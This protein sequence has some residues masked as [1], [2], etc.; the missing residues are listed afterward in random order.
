MRLRAS[1]TLLLALL[2]CSHLLCSALRCRTQ[3]HLRLQLRTPEGLPSRDQP[4]YRTDTAHPVRNMS[5]LLHETERA[6]SFHPDCRRGD[7]G[8][9][10]RLRLILLPLFVKTGL[11]LSA[12]CSVLTYKKSA[13]TAFPLHTSDRQPHGSHSAAKR[14]GS[15][16]PRLP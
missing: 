6:C 3:L 5:F 13:G 14:R 15:L 12:S 7:C 1:F 11:V 9:R 8:G 2:F 16:Y 4:A 10:I